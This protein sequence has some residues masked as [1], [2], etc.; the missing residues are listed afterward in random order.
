MSTPATPI[1]LDGVF[2]DPTA[3]RRLVERNGPYPSIASYLPSSATRATPGDQADGG[4]LPWF[5]ANWAANGLIDVPDADVVLRNPRFLAAA[6]QLFDV[7]R[8]RPTT[9]V[10]NVN[11][12]MGPGAAHVD[13][14]SFHGANR[15]RYALRLLQAMGT[16]GL[17]E[18]WRV[19]EAGVVTWFYDGPGGA[20]DYWPEGLAGPMRSRRPPFDNVALVADNDRMFHRIGWIGDPDATT[21]TLTPTARIFHDDTGRWRIIDHDRIVCTYP[22]ADVRISILWKAQVITETATTPLTTARIAEVITVDLTAR[23]IETPATSDPTTDSAWID[24]VHATYYPAT[25]ALE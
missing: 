6:S 15:D 16:S 12:P 19:V 18:P 1:E 4:P 7:A 25:A 17:F 9:V 14:P 24:V 10:V 3:V 11:A 23:G 22:E 5:R 2:D 21:P 13:I 20:Y 8:V